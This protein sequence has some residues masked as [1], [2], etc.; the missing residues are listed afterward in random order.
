MPPS[1]RPI[2]RSAMLAAGAGTPVLLLHSSASTNAMW[3][4]IIDVLKARFRV[5]A[6]DLIGY[7]RTDPWPAGHEF[8]P[9]EEVYGQ[10]WVNVLISDRVWRQRFGGRSNVLG[11]RLKLNGRVRT[12]VGLDQGLRDR[13]NGAPPNLSIVE[14]SPSYICDYY[15]SD[16]SGELWRHI[17]HVRR[18]ESPQTGNSCA[19]ATSAF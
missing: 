5:I 6:P 19:L 10:N 4:P 1:A 3:A 14:D 13:Y 12:I 9:A 7:G 2:L 18:P 8:T 15:R 16:L 11:R 17:I